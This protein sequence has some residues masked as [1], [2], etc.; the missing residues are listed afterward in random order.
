M[1]QIFSSESLSTANL[2]VDAIY[3][4]DGDGQLASEPISNLLPGCGN[5][6]GFWDSWKGEGQAF[7]CAV[8]DRGGQRLAG[9]NRFSH[10]AVYLL[11]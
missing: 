7:C 5:M 3:E 10:W 4:G 9:Q 1:P 2:I 8:H 11:W 6:G